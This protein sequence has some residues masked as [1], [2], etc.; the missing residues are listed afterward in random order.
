M[1]VELFDTSPAVVAEFDLDEA[2]AAVG[3]SPAGPTVAAVSVDGDVLVARL[4]A[5]GGYDEVRA[6][7]AGGVVAMAWSPDGQALAV[8]TE[9]GGLTIWTEDGPSQRRDL[10]G[11]AEDVTWTAPAQVAVATSEGVW[12]GG[13]GGQGELVA[14]SVG[15]VTALRRHRFGGR[16]SL[17]VGGQL[18]V[19]VLALA[20]TGLPMACRPPRSSDT[21]QV[22]PAASVSTAAVGPAATAV[23]GVVAV[24]TLGGQVLL[25]AAGADPRST[26]LGSQPVEALSWSED[27]RLLAGVIG[28]E[29]R[30]L[31]LIA[32]GGVLGRPLRLD[33]DGDW[34]N[35]ACFS[36]TGT[37][38]AS[39]RSGG[40]VAIH[41]PNE[42]PDAVATTAV[43]HEP[44]NLAW[45][46][47]GL[48]ITAGGRDGSVVVMDASAVVAGSRVTNSTR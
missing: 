7:V 24:G 28:G 5:T 40:E 31:E 10:G 39:A 1:I 25:V 14:S 26:R 11:A 8:I 3:F 23:T 47:S 32:G 19:E 44:L 2:V 30:T 4:G 9:E 36:P 18:G 34:V 38:L 6:R 12:F 13:A 46:T 42:T 41:D 29:L 15:P 37:L 27:G 20:P 17:V 21:A 22:W 43:G 16:P 35:D 45:D 48:M 33:S